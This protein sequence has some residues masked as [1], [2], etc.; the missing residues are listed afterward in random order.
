M[1]NE[2]VQE[3]LIV[4]FVSD[5]YF[6]VRIEDAAGRLNY[7]V[8]WIENA[9]QVAPPDS[10]P[11]ERQTG[12][13]LVGRGAVLLDLL[14]RLKPALII[15]DLSN[16][17]VPWYEW[18]S[19]ISSVP[20]TRRIPILCYGSHVDVET[21]RAARDAGAQVVLARS[22]FFADLPGLLIKHAR[23]P[24]Q[25]A[26]VEACL[27]PLSDLAIRGLEEFNRGEYFEA[28]EHLEAA[29]MAD[30]SLGRD[31]YRAVLQ[32]AVAYYQITRHN[33]RGAAK[34][35]LRLRQWIDPLPDTCRGIDVARLREDA[36][37]VHSELLNLGS[38][39]LAEFDLNLLRPV[40][41]EIRRG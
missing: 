27:Q 32:V 37:Q 17:A 21:I 38:E 22:R 1:M 10:E 11:L 33:Y 16:N 34:M 41:Y 2:I 35:F 12:E 6:A 31:L 25:Q 15:F 26:L 36:R 39:R 14:T 23:V 24:D 7:R 13:H 29:W 40:R 3:P 5:L 4:G 19:L 20:A 30:E 9:D 28:H 18:I 8:K